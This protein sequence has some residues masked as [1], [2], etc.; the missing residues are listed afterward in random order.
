MLAATIIPMVS[1]TT[2]TTENNCIKYRFY[3]AM[4][5]TRF[6]L[7]ALGG[8]VFSY[9]LVA[10]IIGN[11]LVLLSDRIGSPSESHCCKALLWVSIVSFW[12]YQHLHSIW[13]H[14]LIH[15]MLTQNN[16]P[17]YTTLSLS[18]ASAGN[19]QKMNCLSREVASGLVAH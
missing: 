17:L 6:R 18:T 19:T 4:Q 2:T 1:A 15:G 3:I 12:P 13:L 9:R 10:T 11:S 14:D 8:K 5:S 7:V 16:T